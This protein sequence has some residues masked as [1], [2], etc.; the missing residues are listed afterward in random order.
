MDKVIRVGARSSKL[1]IMQAEK[2]IKLL[3]IKGFKTEFVPVTTKGDIDRATPLFKVKEKGIFVKTLENSL[4]KREIDIAVHSA[5]DVPGDIP[6]GLEITT[7]LERETPYDVIISNKYKNIDDIPL[8]A[9][10]GT[11]SVRRM[12]FLRDK[13]KDFRFFPLRGNVD[14]RINKLKNKEFDCI[15]MSEAAIIRLDINI[16]YFRLPLEDFPPAPGQGVVCIETREDFEFKDILREISH[17]KTEIE[18]KTERELLKKLGGGCAIP[19]GCI[20]FFENGEI[21]MR[22]KYKIKDRFKKIYVKGKTVEQT[23]QKAYEELFKT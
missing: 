11:S 15:V 20:A 17:N 1:S 22:A 12:E 14:T 5:K 9:V 21:H 6:D 3:N 2:V 23:A 19:F 4:I 18:I 13:R 16:N 8:N 10:I 7:F